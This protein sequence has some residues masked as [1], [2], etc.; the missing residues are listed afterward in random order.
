MLELQVFCRGNLSSDSEIGGQDLFTAAGLE[1]L[2]QEKDL[3][4][5]NC[6]KK[7]TSGSKGEN[8]QCSRCA[9][10]IESQGH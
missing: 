7:K 5:K 9:G 1:Q 2:C 10:N 4:L 8:N 3:F 6:L